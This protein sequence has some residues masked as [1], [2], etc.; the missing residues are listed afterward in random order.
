M[1]PFGTTF[2]IQRKCFGYLLYFFAAFTLTIKYVL[3]VAWA[4][5]QKAPLTA[6]IFFWDAWWIA[7]I[8]VGYGLLRPAKGIWVWAF[9]L[10]LAEIVIIAVKLTLYFTQPFSDIWH[11]LWAVNKSMML[12]YF[13]IFFGWL[14]HANVRKE[15]A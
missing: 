2:E 4:V 5:A 3:P 9:L 13:V 15:L 11:V 12:V 1:N 10:A 7:H 8:A 14:T 6:Y